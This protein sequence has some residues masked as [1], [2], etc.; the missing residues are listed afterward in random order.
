LDAGSDL[1]G[2]AG[3]ALSV[4]GNAVTDTL[5]GVSNLLSG[6]SERIKGTYNATAEAARTAQRKDQVNYQKYHVQRFDDLVKEFGTGAIEMQDEDGNK[7]HQ[8]RWGQDKKVMENLSAGKNKV[9]INGG[10]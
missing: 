3:S 8:S 5:G 6:D 9:R 10:E 4:L 7:I 2:S 1:G